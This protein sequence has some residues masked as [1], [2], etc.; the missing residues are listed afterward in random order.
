MAKGANPK[1][2]QSMKPLSTAKPGGVEATNPK[3]QDPK[4]NRPTQDEVP[5]GGGGIKGYEGQISR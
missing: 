4:G 1:D 2:G 3:P 5:R